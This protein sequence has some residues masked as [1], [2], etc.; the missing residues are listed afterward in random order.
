M[1]TIDSNDF[2]DYIQHFEKNI[3]DTDVF[4]KQKRT[5]HSLFNQESITLTSKCQPYGSLKNKKNRL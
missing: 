5:L 4:K 3:F 2:S 1:K